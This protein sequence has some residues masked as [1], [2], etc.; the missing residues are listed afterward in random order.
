MKIFKLAAATFLMLF[1]FCGKEQ[2]NGIEAESPVI[3]IES[4]V[5]LSKDGSTRATA[6]VMSPKIV[7]FKSKTHVT[8]L[9]SGSKTCIRTRDNRTGDW[10]E[11]YHIGSGDDN[12]GGAAMV[13][14]SKGYLY[15]FYGPHHSPFKHRVSL[16]PNDASEWGKEMLVGEMATYPSPYVDKNDG[17]HLIYR[18]RE[19]PSDMLYQYKAPGK[20][21]TDPVMLVDGGEYLV[22]SYSN[23][24][25]VDSNGWLHVVFN[26]YDLR[27][28]YGT[29]I[30][31]M[32][33]K[34]KGKTWTNSKDEPYDLPIFFDQVDAVESFTGK[35]LRSGNI[36][37]DSRNNLYFG[38]TRI[39]S[40]GV[41]ETVLVKNTAAGWEKTLINN[42][43]NHGPG[44]ET[45]AQINSCIDSKNNLYIFL[46]VQELNSVWGIPPVETYLL[47]SGDGGKTFSSSRIDKPDTVSV[48]LPNGE[49]FT[50]HNEIDKI[51]LLYTRGNKGGGLHTEVS[52]EIRFTSV[53]LK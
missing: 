47:F 19:W 1:S 21:W 44:K 40:T 50:G 43:V 20:E 15:I 4:P 34:D 18:G 23:S 14:D 8:Y 48:W 35:S 22:V 12:H 9:N 26:F 17:I 39:D 52:T 33:S 27:N 51:N 16:R 37:C 24:L 46:P 31:Y 53:N 3:E 38:I 41:N 11:E 49:R 10:S 25:T 42:Y 28:N 32:R 30:G 13:T 2:E 36:V 5:I 6:Y 45:N 29:K 7:T